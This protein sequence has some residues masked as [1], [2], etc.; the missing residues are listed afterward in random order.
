ML[1]L[2]FLIANAKQGAGSRTLLYNSMF[3][4]QEDIDSLRGAHLMMVLRPE[5]NRIFG[6]YNIECDPG[7][8][9]KVLKR[10]QL[11]H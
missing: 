5:R 3:L 11:R 4:T 7:K 2:S 9:C 6:V 8:L 10:K 1:V